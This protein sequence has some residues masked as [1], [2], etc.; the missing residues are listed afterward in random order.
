[1]ASSCRGNAG[2]GGPDGELEDPPSQSHDRD[3]VEVVLSS[4][5]GAPC[6][7]VGL[8]LRLPLLPP[9][10][11]IAF[12]MPM[13]SSLAAL[14]EMIMLLHRF[15]TACCGEGHRGLVGLLGLSGGMKGL[16]RA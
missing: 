5:R 15:T 14:T 8:P 10:V 12:T 6:D 2:E 7:P 9:R 16:G 13:A 11:A 4:S 1:M 3:S